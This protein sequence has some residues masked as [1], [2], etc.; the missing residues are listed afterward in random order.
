MPA[1]V[2]KRFR[3]HNAEQFHEAFSETASSKMYFF[4]SKVTPWSSESSPP[5]PTENVQDV[6]YNSWKR[7]IAAKRIQTADI[8]F[9]VPRYNWITGKVYRQYDSTSGTLHGVP[10]SSNTFYVMSSEYNVYKCLWNNKAVTST[11]EPTGTATAILNTADGY[12]WKY[13]YTVTA[14]ENLKFVT[15]NWQPVKTLTSDDGSSQW[16]VQAG[17]ANGNIEIIKVTA[18]GTAYMYN[19]GIL[20]AVNNTAA[21]YTLATA[22]NTTDNIYSGSDIYIKSGAGAGQVKTITDYNGTTKVITVATA[23]SPNAAITSVYSIGPKI[24]ITGDGSLAT[25][26]ANVATSTGVNYINMIG[27]GSNYSNATVTVSA[28]SSHGSDAAAVA[29]LPPL[30][31]HGSDPLN[32]LA[33]HNVIM[34]IQ[35]FGTESDTFMTGNDF[36]TMGVVRDPLLASDGTT[37]ATSSTYDQTTRLTLTTVSSAGRYTNDEVITGG[38]STATAKLISFAN[39]NLANTTGTI[40]LT[41]INGAFST[42]ETVT[43]TN[44]GI[45]AV[46]GTITNGSLKKYTGDV[47]YLENRV[48]ISRATDQIEDIKLTV[49]F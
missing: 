33:G 6:S 42:T 23:F 24:N 38:T 49:K 15:V 44:S 32:E 10:A 39:T 7:M 14:A 28:N 45:T 30:G 11:V 5:S 41:D 9:A 2:T 20:T 22:A 31:G 26:Y 34:N 1:L 13:M 48:A 16:D 29:M 25:A 46:V 37:I 4:I 17:A 47:I 18:P 27:T 43:G 12:K 40:K 3:I 8:T 36:R 19:T 35:L 21:T